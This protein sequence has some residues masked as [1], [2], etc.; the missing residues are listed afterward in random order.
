MA[1]QCP[2]CS[3]E[4]EKLSGFVPDATLRERLKAQGEAKQAEI[5]ALTTEVTGLR[6]KASNFDAIVA[7]RDQFRDELTGLRQRE[8]RLGAL[9][10]HELDRSL[11]PHVEVLY[12]SATAGQDEPQAFDA[13][14]E[15]HGKAHPLLAPHVGKE[16]GSAVRPVLRTR[17]T[18]TPPRRE[19]RRPNGR[20][21]SPRGPAGSSRPTTSG[22]TSLGPSFQALDADAKRAKIA[23]LK[24]QV[25]EHPAR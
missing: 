10:G 1:A 5:D 12:A 23:E 20:P 21:S 7:E 8:E 13:W 22:A 18:R 11:L 25:A 6:S 3:Q 24:A 9:D 14:L 4:I 2:H 19:P 15:E 16:D 17:T